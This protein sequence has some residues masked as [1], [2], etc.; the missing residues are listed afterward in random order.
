MTR[1]YSGDIL[2]VDDMPNNLRF[3]S[4]TLTEQGYKVRSV[5][6]GLMALT[7]AEAAKP[8]L[9]LL[10]IMMPNIDGYEV[11]QRLK[12]NEQTCDIPVIF[13]SALDEVLDKV[14]AFNVG[15]V[16]YITKPFQLEEVLARIQTHLSLR[17]AQKEISQLNSELEQRVRQ[18]TAQLEQEIAERLQVQERLLHLALHDVLT[19][20]PNRTWFMKRLEQLLQQVNQQA[21]YRFAVLFLDCDRFQA[22][23]DSLGHLVGDQLLVSI[24]RRIELCL[25]PGTMLCRLG[26]DEFAILLQDTEKASDAIKVSNDILLEL[27]APFQ[28]GDYQVFTNVSIGIAMGS[29]IYKQPEH[30][31]RDADTA[32]YRAKANGKACYQMFEQTMHSRALHNFQLE[33]DLRH[34]LERHEL[35]AYYQPII[36]LVNNQI[37]S[38]EALVRWN[39]PEKGLIDPSKFIPIAEETGL[40]IAIDLFILQ[41]SCQQLRSWRD[42]GIADTSLTMNVNLSVKHFMSFDLLEH[43]D[44]VLQETGIIGNSLRLEITESD[45]MENAEFAGKIISQLR[46]RQIKLSIDDFGTGYS[47]LSYL[48]RLPIDHLKIDRSFVMRIGKNG[49]NTEIIKAIIALAKSLDMFTIAEGVETQDQLDQIRELKCE[50][51]QGY[52]FSRP[53]EASQARNLLIA[54]F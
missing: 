54:G 43:I 42:E 37:D 26:G 32:M 4:T 34:A 25:K 50:F 16:D 38:F 41:Q 31:L 14:K 24:S 28:I 5:T 23:N 20:L 33:S 9:I 40:V 3:L 17:F 48:H 13:L 29:D 2:I 11:C 18:R 21:G 8:D 27:A 30:I 10:D 52:L 22:V 19:G 15:G 47:S 35:V 49:K 53:V 46:D 45:I 12:A 51:C 36:N 7:V 39:H 6:E 44:R 1:N